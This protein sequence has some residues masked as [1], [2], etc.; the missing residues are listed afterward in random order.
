MT[1]SVLDKSGDAVA[2]CVVPELVPAPWRA[3]VSDD[4]LQA[5]VMAIRKRA[6]FI[7]RRFTGILLLFE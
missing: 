5:I 6:I 4:L 7:M 3:G 1:G 2:G